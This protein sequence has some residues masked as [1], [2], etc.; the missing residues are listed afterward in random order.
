MFYEQ[1]ILAPALLLTSS[2]AANPMPH[3]RDALA[4]QFQRLHPTLDTRRGIAYE[5]RINRVSSNY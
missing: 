5:S 2:S 1:Q 4:A 3:Q